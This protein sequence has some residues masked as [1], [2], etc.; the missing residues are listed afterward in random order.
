M[1][2][3][4]NPQSAQ[5]GGGAADAAAHNLFTR[6]SRFSQQPPRSTSARTNI[7][8]INSTNKPAVIPSSLQ[9]QKEV[10]VDIEEAVVGGAL[11]MS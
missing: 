8:S 2:Q 9:K 1:V 4:E 11:L 3:R 7:R 6:L 5:R 10:I